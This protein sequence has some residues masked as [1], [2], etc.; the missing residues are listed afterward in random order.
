MQAVTFTQESNV[1]I[2]LY[3]AVLLYMCREQTCHHALC[4][5][6]LLARHAGGTT[7]WPGISHQEHSNVT[8]IL[9]TD[10][11]PQTYRQYSQNDAV[12]AASR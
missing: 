2:V 1:N 7:C 11:S 8:S 9:V 12:P 5:V 3:D 10:V 6:Q 4:F